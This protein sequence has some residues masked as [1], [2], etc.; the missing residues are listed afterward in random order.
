MPRPTLLIAEPE[1]LQAISVRKL[2]L[3]TAKFNV[4]TAHSG[5]EALDLLRK[6]PAVEGV[7]VHSELRDAAAAEVFQDVKKVDA[8][9]PTILLMSGVARSR[10]DADY[11]IASD[12][13]DTLLQLVRKLFG[14]PRPYDSEMQNLRP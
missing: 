2:I 5:Q 13:P 12:E 4:V 7:I 6:F 1:P 9:K 3:E 10:K 8:R 14:D 11:T